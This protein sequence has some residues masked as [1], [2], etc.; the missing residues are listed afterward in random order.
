MLNSGAQPGPNSRA[1]T[2]DNLDS[3]QTGLSDL[4]LANVRWRMTSNQVSRVMLY[5][6][7]FAK[8][9]NQGLSELREE[10]INWLS[11]RP[12]HAVEVLQALLHKN[13]ASFPQPPLERVGETTPE[14]YSARINY[15]FQNQD[16]VTDTF[17]ANRRHAP[18]LAQAHLLFL[19]LGRGELASLEAVQERQANNPWKQ[20]VDFCN[21]R[22]GF[23]LPVVISKPVN[24]YGVPHMQVEVS[25][26][27]RLK[28]LD[29]ITETAPTMDEAKM[30]AAISLL[31][32]LKQRGFIQ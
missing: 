4:E 20:L 32:K 11:T 21:Q 23:N 14:K 12:I 9:P 5:E 31:A 28:P 22:R 13:Q 18:I 6:V 2:P 15:I 25:L 29:T 10:I 19:I 17:I 3:Q 8:S 16:Y 26:K 30:R 1:R 27:F 7:L 24:L